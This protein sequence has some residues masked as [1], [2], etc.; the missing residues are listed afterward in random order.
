MSIFECEYDIRQTRKVL[1]EIRDVLRDI[2][3]E[4]RK[5]KEE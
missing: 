2:L 4:M 5:P 3:A 1:E